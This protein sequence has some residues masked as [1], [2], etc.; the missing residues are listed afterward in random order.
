MDEIRREFEKQFQVNSLT[1]DI[2]D[3]VDNDILIAFMA[4]NFCDNFSKEELIEI[5]DNEIIK[6]FGL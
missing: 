1:S 3:L 5:F 4:K 2:M 6:E